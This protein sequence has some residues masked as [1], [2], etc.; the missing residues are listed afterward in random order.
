M[1]A[2]LAFKKMKRFFQTPYYNLSV[3]WNINFQEKKSLILQIE[4]KLAEYRSMKLSFGIEKQD[5][6][7]TITK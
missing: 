1:K 7:T 3:R 5:W 4:Q 6:Y 2:E